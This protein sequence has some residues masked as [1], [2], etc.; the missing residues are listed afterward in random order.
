MCSDPGRVRRNNE[1]ACALAPE[2]GAYVVC[3]GMGGAAGGEIAS[4]LAISTF[5]DQLA[6]TGGLGRTPPVA[7][8]EAA[9]EAAN[10]AVHQHSLAHPELAGMGTT[11]VALLYLRPGD[12]D[13]RARPRLALPRSPPRSAHPPD[14]FLLN[15][16]DSRCYRLRDGHLV[17]L[18]TDHSFVEE[19]LR[20]GQITAEQAADSPMRNYITRAIGPGS[21]VEAELERYRTRSGDL[22]LLC[23][24]GLTRELTTEQMAD[25]LTLHPPS[26]APAAADLDLLLKRLVDAANRNGG[27]DNITAI[28]LA[29]P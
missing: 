3:D 7:R 5:L 27:H 24:D 16:G 18:S 8:L 11:L 2:L 22:Y 1:D 17:Q 21:R 23:S 12:H 25:V 9:L 10:R 6:L 26:R 15:V 4:H 19:Q 28:L 20:A 13:R 29:C 14:L